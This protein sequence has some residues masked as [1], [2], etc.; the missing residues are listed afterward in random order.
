M[1][2]HAILVGVV[3]LSVITFA[4]CEE[5]LS[6]GGKRWQNYFSPFCPMRVTR[7]RRT[8]FVRGTG[9][10]RESVARHGRVRRLI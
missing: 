3:T 2:E 7:G 4:Y 1:M 10:D 9:S 5:T 6:I 8:R